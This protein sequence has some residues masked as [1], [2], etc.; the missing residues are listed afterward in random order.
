MGQSPEAMPGAGLLRQ[1]HPLPLSSL[2]GIEGKHLGSCIVMKITDQCR[3]IDFAFQ[4]LKIHRRVFTC[5]HII[6]V[7]YA[8]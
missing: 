1:I 5:T 8:C 3:S 4:A 2:V 7:Y 6:R